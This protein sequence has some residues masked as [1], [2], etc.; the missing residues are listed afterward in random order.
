[1]NETLAL[2]KYVWTRYRIF[3]LILIPVLLLS[4]I[5]IPMLLVTGAPQWLSGTVAGS[6]FLALLV[7]LIGSIVLFGFSRQSS[8]LDPKSNYDDWLMHLPISNWKL[9]IIPA[10]LMTCWISAVWT[11]AVIVIRLVGGR[12]IPIVSQSLGMSACAIIACSLVWMPFRAGWLRI[13]LTMVALPLLY[14]VGMG[15][16]VLSFESPYWTPWAVAGIVAC[17]IAALVVAFYSVTLARVSSFQQ[18]KFIR[19]TAASQPAAAVIARSFVTWQDALNWHDRTRSRATKLRQVL[20]MSPL[21]AILIWLVPLSAAS[22]ICAMVII[23]AMV[24]AVVSTRLEPTV[25]GARSSLPSYLIASPLPSRTMAYVRLRAFATE[26]VGVMFIM[27]V[28]WLSCFAWQSNREA[29]S[30]WWLSFDGANAAAMTPLRMTVAIYLAILVTML[31]SSLRHVCI[32]LRGRQ[33]IVLWM[34]AVCCAALLSPLLGFLGWFTQQRDWGHVA[35]AAE[36]TVQWSYQL[37]YVALAAKLAFDCVVVCFASKSM[38]S[39]REILTVVMGWCA[40]VVACSIAWYALWPLDHV[41]F[42]TVLMTTSLAIPL[43]V[44]FAGPLGLRA[45]RHHRVVGLLV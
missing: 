25:W 5:F 35:A 28:L 16:M 43:S 1:M 27:T 24:G 12:S 38:F 31:G 32:Q 29:A 41:Q 3:L 40:L 14:F 33:P 9:A 15:A 39:W 42:I 2:T 6:G 11:G 8:L 13:M 10:G 30:R 22:A 23:A 17:Y 36:D 20:A 4:G 45:N 26:Y 7:A 19:A 18:T 21:V 44:C 34:V 37:F